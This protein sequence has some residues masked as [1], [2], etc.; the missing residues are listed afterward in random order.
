[1]SQRKAVSSEAVRAWRDVIRGLIGSILL[2]FSFS[3]AVPAVASQPTPRVTETMTRTSLLARLKQVPG[4]SAKFRE[5]KRIEL[6]VAPLVS[7]GTL[8]YVPPGRL[9]RHTLEPAKH[10]VLIDRGKLTVGDANGRQELDL[11]ANPVIRL[12]VEGF[13]KVLAGDGEALMRT[14]DV[15]FEAG[16]GRT[17]TMVLRPK[18]APLDKLVQSITFRGEDVVIHAMETVEVG[19]DVTL[20]TFTD[21]D[22]NRKYNAEEL[23]R[24]FRL[25]RK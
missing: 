12:L 14:Y 22:T 13:V 7:K 6:L 3:V 20:T 23:R 5:E 25:P 15:R 24:I 4:L 21:V 19:G 2:V 17:W 10:T 16:E 11:H 18:V 1:V 8:H 9:A